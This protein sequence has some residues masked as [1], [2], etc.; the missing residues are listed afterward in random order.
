MVR[1]LM[2]LTALLLAVAG[3]GGEQ[4]AAFNETDVMFAQMSVEHIRQ[5]DQVVALAEQ[6]ATDPE[7]TA[8]ATELRAQWR[9]EAETMMGWLARWQRPLTPDPDAG[10]HAGHGD[11]HSLRAV[12]IAELSAAPGE[13]FDRTAL[14]LLLGHLHN[15]VETA[16]METAGGRYPPAINLA[17][18]TITKRQ[19]Q[20]QR[21]LT[22]MA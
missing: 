2:V 20:V 12:D 8:L 6:R 13:T 19:S 21:M 3:C 15:G 17:A 10:A 18:A 9:D 22:L 4:P 7:V 16:R 14:G 11:L 5:G 1:R